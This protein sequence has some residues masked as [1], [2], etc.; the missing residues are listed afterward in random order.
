MKAVRKKPAQHRLQRTA[1]SP[2]RGTRR[3]PAE[4]SVGEGVLPVS[5]L[6]LKPTVSPPNLARSAIIPAECS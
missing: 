2:L 5:P 3:E 6:P 1:A 4:L